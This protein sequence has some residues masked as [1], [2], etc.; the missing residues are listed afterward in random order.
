MSDTY[1][2]S[3]VL[4]DDDT[5]DDDDDFE[6]HES[7]FYMDSEDDSD[8]DAGDGFYPTRDLRY[9]RPGQGVP[10]QAMINDPSYGSSETSH[11]RRMSHEG[12]RKEKS[13]AFKNSRAEAR[14]K[15]RVRVRLRT[16]ETI[17]K[18]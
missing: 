18:S 5:D 6:E 3:Y 12:K 16:P 10:V 4:A 7:Y 1:G 11:T 8:D 15:A 14:Q 2:P 9:P 13:E 17:A